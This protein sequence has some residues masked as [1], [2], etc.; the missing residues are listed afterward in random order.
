MQ[1]AQPVQRHPSRND[2][3]YWVVM[4]GSI[5]SRSPG[6]SS[7]RRVSRGLEEL[8]KSSCFSRLRAM[9]AESRNRT[10]QSFRLKLGD[11]NNHKRT[12]IIEK[13]VI[14]GRRKRSRVIRAEDGRSWH[15][16][17]WLAGDWLAVYFNTFEGTFTWIR[18]S[19][20]EVLF[21]ALLTE[22][23]LISMGSFMIYISSE[24]VN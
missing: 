24:L 3:A 4:V 23:I 21:K 20:I 11:L 17:T 7:S 5:L 2:I 6:Q 13:K 8:T 14:Q 22:D 18:E 10:I 1:L 9:L 12:D 16:L 19:V 15:R